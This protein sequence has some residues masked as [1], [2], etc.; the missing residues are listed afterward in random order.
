MLVYHLN[1][2]CIPA[3][4][5]A[6]GLGVYRVAAPLLTTVLVH[7]QLTD[8]N[9]PAPLATRVVELAKQTGN[10][11]IQPLLSHS[12]DGGDCLLFWNLASGLLE[13]SGLL[14]R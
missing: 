11:V 13:L 7:A 10:L 2:D 3:L 4:D 5:T 12:L 1:T 8:H 6:V 14:I 9:L